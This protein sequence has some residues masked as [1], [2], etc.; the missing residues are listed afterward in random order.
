M[1][2]DNPELKLFRDTTRQLLAGSDSGA[3]VRSLHASDMAFDRDWW[4][5][6]AD[7]GWT[8]LAAP[9]E[10]GGGSITGSPI[11]DLVVLAEEFGRHA[12]PGPLLP[13]CTVLTGLVES[14]NASDHRDTIDNIVAGKRV[15]AWA[16]SG[17]GSPAHLQPGFKATETWH[18]YL[19]SGVAERVEAAAQADDLLVPVSAPGGVM[20]FLVSPA[21]PGVSV[22][23]AR[24]I[25]LVRQYAT[26]AMDNV[27][28][29]A[30]AQV[31][32]SV[33]TARVMER[34]RQIAVLLRCAETVGVI[35]KAFELTLQWAFDRYSFG[36]P[37]AS[38]QALKHRYADM[39]MWVQSCQ[40]ITNAAA[41]AVQRRDPDA[42]VLLS[43]AKSYVGE[44][45]VEILQDCIQ[46]HGGIGVTWEHD[47]HLYMRRAALNCNT[48]GTPEDHQL[49][50]A[51]HVEREQSR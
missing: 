50:L 16:F 5:R 43:V 47:L 38:Y 14:N 18:G 45:G 6:A 13:V 8:A 19:I 24:S 20:Q 17:D 40:A 30:T 15:P 3:A 33:D 48:F 34:Q 4:A 1:R 44:R 49:F 10:F 42:S 7:L 31:G 37:L 9:E 22:A 25:D 11:S 35:G 46:L 2:S 29:P 51:D 21:T 32:D 41:A 27:E 36:R 26:V 28:V 39:F 12:A 23:R